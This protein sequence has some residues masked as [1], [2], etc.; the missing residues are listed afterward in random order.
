MKK[1]VLSALMLALALAGAAPAYAQQQGAA[2]QQVSGDT[3]NAPP[4]SLPGVVVGTVTEIS[5]SVVLVEEDPSSDAGAKGYFTVTDETAISKQQGEEWVSA[6][7]EELAV[8]QRVEAAY[9]GE[10]A[11]SDPP[12]GNAASIAILEDPDCP[13]PGG[14]KGP[15]PE[16]TATLSFELTVKGEPPAAA[17]FSGVTSLESLISTP[18]TDPDGDGLY[19][20]SVEVPVTS[21]GQG[22]PPEPLSLPVRIVQDGARVIKDFGLVRIDG[23]KT[24]EASVSFDGTEP[25]P[26]EEEVTATGIVERLEAEPVVVDGVEICGLSTHAIADEATGAY[27]DLTSEAVDLD[28]YAGKRVAVTGTPLGSPAIGGAGAERCPDLEVT[29]VEPLDGGTE[30]PPGGTTPPPAHGP[31]PGADLNGDGSVDASDGEEAAR[32]SDAAAS[33]KS[34]ERMLPNTGGATLALLVGAGALLTAAGL[35]V[36]RA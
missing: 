12:Q 24:F 20:G 16:D 10:F 8:G 32:V 28:A 35:L 15:P 29:R 36:R 25:P 33:E 9:D 18:L 4:D 7:F 19:T 23:D 27:Y 22:G 2:E 3:S 26:P 31:A 34:G 1:L 30:P 13:F 21:G 5:G 6:I 14:C 17:T 11:T